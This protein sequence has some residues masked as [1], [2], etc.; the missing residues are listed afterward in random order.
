M[1]KLPYNVVIYQLK[2]DY[3]FCCWENRKIRSLSV[4]VFR[5]IKGLYKFKKIHV[6]LISDTNKML[7]Q[8]EIMIFKKIV[9]NYEKLSN[10]DWVT[11][12][13]VLFIIQVTV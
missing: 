6:T 12:K 3:H 4:D 11:F 10:I 7:Q 8:K 1:K 9:K 5:K 2:S 13:N